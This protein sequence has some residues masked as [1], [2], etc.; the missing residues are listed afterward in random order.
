MHEPTAAGR[1]WLLLLSL[2]CCAGAAVAQPQAAPLQGVPAQDRP[3]QSWGFDPALLAADGEVLLRRAPDAAVDR[4]FQAVHRSAQR[5]DEAQALCALF[6]PQADRSL[7]GLNATASR[8]GPASRQDFAN[9]LAEV[10]IGAAQHPPQPYDEP[11]ARQA[12]KAAGVRAALI[13][14]GFAAGLNGSAQDARCRS[15]GWLLEQLHGRPLAE[16]AA[17]TRLLL[18]EGLQQL[19]G[20]D[21]AAPAPPPPPL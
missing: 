6:D 11:A 8:L 3:L 1:R 14:D 10:F 18:G 16:R 21:S 20:I 15:L 12:L 2:S 9:A 13:N 5:P 17:V 19:A 4:L 7:A